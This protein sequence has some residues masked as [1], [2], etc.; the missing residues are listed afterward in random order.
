ME[1]CGHETRSV[2]DRYN[3]TTGDDRRRA[4]EKLDAAAA[5]LGKVVGKVTSFEPAAAVADSAK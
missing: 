4:A 2:F 5:E 1:M 3:I